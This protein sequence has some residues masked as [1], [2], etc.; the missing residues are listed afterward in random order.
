M[1][2]VKSTEW[3]IKASKLIDPALQNK[4]GLRLAIFYE[5]LPDAFTAQQANLVG[6][7]MNFSPRMV[8]KNL[9]QLQ[10]LNMIDKVSR[11]LYSKTNKL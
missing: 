2:F 4:F 3:L 8:C 5:L 10:A 1:N 9:T 7:V 6:C 11:S